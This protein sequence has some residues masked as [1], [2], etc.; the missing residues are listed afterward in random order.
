MAGALVG[1]LGVRSGDRVAILDKN[2]D[3]YMELLFALDKAGAVSVPVNW[4]LTASEVG[5]VVGDAA[6]VALVVGEEFR[7]AADQVSCR[8]LGL[9]E[10]P[11]NGADPHRDAEAAVTWQLYTPGTTGRPNGARP[12]TLTL[13]A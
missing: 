5:K 4:R 6:P 7:A 9:G 11:R 3:D 12:S 13:C 8:V 10:L 2:S 1:E